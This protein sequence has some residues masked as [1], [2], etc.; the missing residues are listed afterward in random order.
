MF[1]CLG[2][3]LQRIGRSFVASLRVAVSESQGLTNPAS[4]ALTHCVSAVAP[5][6]RACCRHRY[7]GQ[8]RCIGA[9]SHGY[10]PLAPLCI[11]CF[12]SL[13]ARAP[14]RSAPYVALCRGGSNRA[15][16]AE[17]PF[18][19]ETTVPP[20]G[21]SLLMSGWPNIALDNGDLVR[22][23]PSQTSSASCRCER[24]DVKAST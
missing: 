16:A 22:E 9:V 4:L 18:A 23:R 1:H 14:R 21:N 6:L 7:G 20:L 19:S 5:A 24:L 17:G 12:R 13:V 8:I 3:K 2:P 10:A 11:R 15:W